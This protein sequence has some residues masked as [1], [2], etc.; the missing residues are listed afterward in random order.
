MTADGTQL[1]FQARTDGPRSGWFKKLMLLGREYYYDA[2]R[3]VTHSGALSP[4]HLATL[5]ALVTMDTHR[6][7]KGLAVPH[8]KPWFGKLIVRRVLHNA[9]LYARLDG[10]ANVCRAAVDAVEDYLDRNSELGA[11]EPEWAAQIR[12]AVTGLHEQLQPA[13]LLGGTKTVS[14]ET[15][16]KA[17]RLDSMDFF[18][19]RYSIRDFAPEPVPQERIEAAVAAAQHTPSVC[20]R[21]SW[22]VHVFPRGPQAGA[23]LACQ[24]G[25]TGFGHTASH[26][27]LITTDLRTFV[28]PGERNQGWVDGGMFAMSLIHAFHAQGIGTCCL[29]WSVDSRA[30]RRLRTVA[31][32]PAHE[33][34]IMML[35]VGQLPEELRVATSW[36][37]EPGHVIRPGRIRQVTNQDGAQ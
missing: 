33:N 23:V 2:T 19:S 27:L 29:N 18:T 10:D 13:G 32:I 5:R 31:E 35:A 36:R 12:R 30:D 15:I 8:P 37:P 6:V 16:H 20:N 9:S 22:S 14:R 25:N 3:F 26:I 17:G 11:P 1:R 4:R 28:Y 7:E 24:N 34:V 21:Q